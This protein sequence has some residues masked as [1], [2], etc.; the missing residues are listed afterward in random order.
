[1]IPLQLEGGSGGSQLP[2][3]AYYLVKLAQEKA[4]LLDKSHQLQKRIA[5]EEK[6]IGE[7]D[8]AIQLMKSSNFDYRSENIRLNKL[9]LV[10]EQTP[11]RWK[12]QR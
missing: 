6:E 4:E 9:S 12:S 11:Q 10:R 8:K 7:L 1:M 3:H 2:S 5:K